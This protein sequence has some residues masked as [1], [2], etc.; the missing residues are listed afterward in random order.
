MADSPLAEAPRNDVPP[1]RTP[2]P[3]DDDNDDVESAALLSIPATE[4]PRPYT[5]NTE[6]MPPGAAAAREMRTR[7]F[8]FVF[9]IVPALIGFGI[10]ARYSTS[11]H[12]SGG[13]TVG[14][15]GAS[16]NGSA[17]GNGTHAHEV[18]S[19]VLAAMRAD[20]TAPTVLISIDGFRHDY[21][22]RRGADG[23]YLA[24]SLRRLAAAGV[25]SGPGG[26]K[27]V[28][29]TKTFP[30]HWSLAT[31]LYPE[32]HGIVG[33]TMYSQETGQ[34]F[35]YAGRDEH[36]WE[37]EPVWQT[38]QRTPRRF[39][40]NA[41][42]TDVDRAA[43]Y[44][45]GC[46][47]WV[48]SDVPKHLCDMYWP[49]DASV[50]YDQRVQRALD[51]L[52]GD[53]DEFRRRHA[54]EGAARYSQFVTLYFDKVDHEGHLHGPASAQVSR[55]IVEVDKAIGSLLAGIDARTHGSGVDVN[56]VVVSDHGFT[57]VSTER[58][59]Q[60]AG[61]V[62]PHTVQDVEQSPLGVWLNVSE[63]ADALFDQLQRAVNDPSN[64]DGGKVRAAVFRKRDI[65]DRWHIKHSRFISPVIT[66]ADIG[67]TVT[68]PHEH[69]LRSKH[70]ARD[71]VY[72]N[73][74]FDNDEPDMQATFIAAGPAFKTG[75][76]VEGLSVLD[77]YPL[78]CKLFGASPAP[79]NGSLDISLTNIFK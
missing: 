35:H 28:F 21:L 25:R 51:L 42:F 68:F 63:S 77:V 3:Q 32:T 13:S 72:G 53:A 6:D 75:A 74:G 34:W 24:P 76:V 44:S 20:K 29:P 41:N 1:E 70:A 46:V 27:P 55:E 40:A 23:K 64:K 79:H 2:P 26:M 17:S 9:V 37:G 57:E 14:G 4:S 59:V 30:N 56:V 43:N 47:F 15:D 71:P 61:F 65:P 60:L 5:M 19:G 38:L 69:L 39:R 52:F 50:P 8:I 78:I 36:W 18:R 49:Y 10:Y 73:H 67:Y 62:T 48:G 58:V 45:A 12:A 33:N 31:G 11:K 54:G 7:V 66:V 16:R 22:E